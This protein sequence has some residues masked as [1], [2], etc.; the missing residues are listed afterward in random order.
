MA[1]ERPT[2]Q[3]EALRF[4]TQPSAALD[5]LEPT[6]DDVTSP[7]VHFQSNELPDDWEP[8]S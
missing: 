7:D 4:S 5:L 6:I 1:N 8:F 3:P 2:E